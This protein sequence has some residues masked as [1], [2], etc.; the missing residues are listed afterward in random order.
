MRQFRATVKVGGMWVQTII[1]A[2]NATIALKL[3]QASY[4]SSN[5]QGT[6]VPL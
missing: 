6:P 4:G 5:V 1:F 2:D 3:A